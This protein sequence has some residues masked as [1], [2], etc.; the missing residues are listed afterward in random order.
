MLSPEP[1]MVEGEWS[2]FDHIILII[3]H[4]LELNKR[5]CLLQY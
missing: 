2:H 4:S 5:A 1:I 3:I